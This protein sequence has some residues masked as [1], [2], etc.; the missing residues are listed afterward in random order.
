MTS[1]SNKGLFQRPIIYQIC[2]NHFLFKQELARDEE[3]TH[4]RKA[5]LFKFAVF[6]IYTNPSNDNSLTSKIAEIYKYTLSTLKR[7]KMDG[8]YINN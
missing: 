4:N 3:A 1:Q 6:K 8:L 5:M 2:E 7:D